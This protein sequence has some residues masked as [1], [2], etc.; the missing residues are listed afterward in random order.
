MTCIVGCSLGGVA[1]RSQGN[2]DFDVEDLSSIRR[3]STKPTPMEEGISNMSKLTTLA[4]QK[5]SGSSW[6]LQSDVRHHRLLG[7]KE[8]A[9][10]EH[11]QAFLVFSKGEFPGALA[12][13]LVVSSLSIE[14]EQGNQAGL[15]YRY[16]KTEDI[17][18]STI[19]RLNASG[20]LG[21]GSTGTVYSG[22]WQGKEVAVKIAEGEESR[23]RL[24]S[25]SVWYTRIAE[26]EAAKDIL[27]TF[28]GRFRHASFDVLVLS[29]EGSA[30]DSWND[31]VPDERY[32]LPH[33]F[34]QINDILQTRIILYG[35]KVAPGWATSWGP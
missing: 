10:S 17:L 9:N 24:Q 8:T 20:F 27:P 26:R 19:P 4:R 30:L 25:E 5:S 1:T 11:S 32:V 33:V 34:L 3:D 13:P 31:L 29:K 6:T 7:G 22:S 18:S 15:P 21:R 35:S 2:F 28:F 16:W 14:T 12:A 23:D